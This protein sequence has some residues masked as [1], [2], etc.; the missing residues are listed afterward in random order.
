MITGDNKH[1]AKEV[2]EKTGVTDFVAEALPDTKVSWIE[3]LKKEGHKVVMVG[4]GINDS[5][6]LSA[7]NVGIAMGKASSIASET[8]DILLPDDGLDSLPVLRK[9]SRNLISRIH[10]NN[11]AIIGI[12]SALIAGGLA[13]SITP[14][15]AALLHNSS[16]VAISVN[17]MSSLD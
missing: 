13:G 2:A 9:I 15:M 8:A 10:G 14:Q 11:R 12:N 1:T 16:T 6:A 4:D 17:A 7:A 5:P 3:K